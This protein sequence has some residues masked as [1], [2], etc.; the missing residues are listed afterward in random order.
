M[1][2][3]DDGDDGDVGEDGAAAGDTTYDEVDDNDNY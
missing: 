3:G 1:D 2:G